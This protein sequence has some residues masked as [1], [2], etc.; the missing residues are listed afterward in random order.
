[1]SLKRQL[2]YKYHNFSSSV[3]TM[4]VPAWMTSPTMRLGLIFIILF[5]GFA[6]IINITSSATSG[7]QVRALEKQTR[8]LEVAVRKLEVEIAD[9]SSITAIAAKIERLGMVEAAGVKHVAVK[10]SSVAKN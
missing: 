7:Y 3:R 4:T 1:M 10:N 6:Y 2:Q 8:D 5:F 9:N